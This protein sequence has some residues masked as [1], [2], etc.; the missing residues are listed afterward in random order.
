MAGEFTLQLTGYA[1]GTLNLLDNSNYRLR[2]GWQP[3]VAKRRKSLFGGIL[4]EDVVETLPIGCTGVSAVAAL[5]NLHALSAALD[6]AMVWRQNEGEGVDPI[7]IKYR[8]EGSSLTNPLQAP[9]VDVPEQDLM[10]L[11][12][13]FNRDIRAYEV[14]VDLQVKRSGQWLGDEESDSSATAEIGYPLT[15]TWTDELALPSP[16]DIDITGLTV[17]SNY[18]LLRGGMIFVNDANDY[19]I[20]EAESATLSNF[21]TVSSSSLNYRGGSG[22]SLAT[23]PATMTLSITSSGIQSGLLCIYL[24][25][26]ISATVSVYVT[27]ANYRSNSGILPD[28]TAILD[29][30]FSTP[31]IH[32][33]P[34]VPMPVQASTIKLSFEGTTVAIDYIVVVPAGRHHFIKFADTRYD[35]L[36]WT[37]QYRHKLL[38][39]R[40]STILFSSGGLASSLTYEGSATINMVGD[41]LICIP[42][43]TGG[44]NYQLYRY[45]YSTTTVNTVGMT[46]TRRPAYLVPQ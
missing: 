21:D 23:S 27:N 30:S 1:G 22:V 16:V 32:A 46:A 17:G 10:N 33:I 40:K 19:Q 13:T 44:A 42:A 9:V 26:R 2:R 24:I 4:Y 34:L 25:G 39:T 6:Q 41:T 38:T 29:Q 31:T 8:A 3:R 11:Q 20:F 12:P 14:A 28:A 36:A 37:M 43:L 18:N 35:A 15:C 7:I 5:N 45:G